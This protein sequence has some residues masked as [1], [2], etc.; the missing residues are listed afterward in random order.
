VARDDRLHINHQNHNSHLKNSPTGGN[1]M[2]TLDQVYELARQ[3]IAPHQKKIAIWIL[4]RICEEAHDHAHAHHELG[5]LYFERNEPHK[6][7]HYLEQAASIDPENPC[8]TKDLGDFYH[9]VHNDPHS[10]LEKYAAALQQQ[11]DDQDTLLKAGHL[12]MAA[13]QYEMANDCY[14]RILS[15]NPNHAEVRSFIEK[16]D[17]VLESSI[18]QATP[19]ELYSQAHERLADGDKAGALAL[20]DQVIELD[21]Q[22]ALAH[23]DRGVLSFEQNDK[24]KTRYHYEQAVTLA[25]ENATFLKNLADFYWVEQGD[26]GKALKQYLQV[27]QMAPPDA[28]TLINCG[29]ICMALKKSEDA[30]DFFIHAQQIEPCN[31][32]VKKLLNDL[33]QMTRNATHPIDRDALYRQAQSAAAAGDLASAIAH[34]T[35]ILETEPENATIFN[36]IGVLNYE[37]GHLSN[38]LSSYEQAVRLEPDHTRFQKNLADF[39]MMEQG[40]AEDAMKLYIKILEKDPQDLDCLLA[41][42]LLCISMKQPDDAKIFF[43]RVLDIEPW[44]VSAKQGL[45]RLDDAGYK[46]DAAGKVDPGPIDNRQIAN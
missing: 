33:E 38:A 8:F 29:Q 13:K 39:Y 16:L 26:A 6:A 34:L 25:P 45:E 37:A 4:E 19:E 7:Q 40:R 18:K 5:M 10:A 27:L 43:Q 28:E 14:T 1:P 24:E 20:L 46:A 11:P 41:C 12:Y 2:S 23:N 31:Q 22:N 9:V 17:E 36:D 3:Q 32:N 21:P 35:R 15:L 30:H 42:G 44:N